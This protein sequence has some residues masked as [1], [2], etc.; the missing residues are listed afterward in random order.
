M[1]GSINATSY[2]IT[3]T[4]DGSGQ[5]VHPSIVYFPNRWGGYRYWLGIT[6]YPNGNANY[7]N[8]SILVS[9]DGERWKLP[10]G[11][12]NP[13][14]PKPAKGH[15]ADP[16]LIY[17]NGTD[18]L[19]CYYMNTGVK[20]NWLW[21]IKSS[22]GSDWSK[23]VYLSSGNGIVS[24]TIVKKDSNWRMWAVDPSEHILKYY[25][26]SDGKNWLQQQDL[27]WSIVV[28]GTVYA[29]WHPKVRWIEEKDEYW[30]L[31]ATVP[32]RSLDGA[33]C[34]LAY[35]K[36]I[37]G[38]KW[39]TYDKLILEPS[40]SRWDNNLIYRADFLYKVLPNTLKIWYSA[41]SVSAIWHLGCTSRNYDK[42]MKPLQR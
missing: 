30:L 31:M 23:P 16:E 12:T 41:N 22:N 19:G 26:S 28:E 15:Y 17:N 24:P 11:I 37:D 18:E 14:V 38:I 3:P 20:P 13:L 36:S 9:N 5:V 25:I 8:P 6:P 1:R 32:V 21:L 33:D 34:K 27:V 7:E 40:S 35:A 39:T 2:Q 29:P 10:A 42:F 4:Y